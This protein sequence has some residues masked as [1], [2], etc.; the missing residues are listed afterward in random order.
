MAIA[1]SYSYGCEPVN[2]S[3]FR[4]IIPEQDINY[5][6]MRPRSDYIHWNAVI[7][8]DRPLTLWI[9]QTLLSIL[10]LSEALLLVYLGY[11]RAPGNAPSSFC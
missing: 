6:D 1:F 7:W 11:K 10:S 3:M 2:V 9:F 5:N 8:V 4:E